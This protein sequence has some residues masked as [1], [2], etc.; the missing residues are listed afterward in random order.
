MITPNGKTNETLLGG[1]FRLLLTQQEKL[2]TG[3]DAADAAFVY[4]RA[5]NTPLIEDTAQAFVTGLL[6]AAVAPSPSI[7]SPPPIPTRCSTP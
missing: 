6:P 4:V 1:Y 5:N 7:P 3:N 2:L